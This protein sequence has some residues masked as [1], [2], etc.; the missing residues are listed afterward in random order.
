MT[1]KPAR[2]RVT[3]VMSGRC[4]PPAN[5]SFRIQASPGAGV[6]RAY[7]GDGVGKRAEVDRD[8][9]GLRDHPP[10]RVEE[11][12]RAVAPLLDVRG[13]GGADEGRAH[14]VRDRAERGTDHL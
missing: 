3:S 2:V 4:V 14:L 1:A 11:G 6:V 5:G 7:R 12:G 10:A 9:L 8:V 13:E